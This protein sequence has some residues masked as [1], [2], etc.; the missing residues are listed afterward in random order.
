MSSPGFFYSAEDQARNQA[1]AQQQAYAQALLQQGQNPGNAQYGGLRSAGNSI[2]GAFLAKRAQDKELELS[3]GVQDRRAA[4]WARLLKGDQSPQVSTAAGT[5]PQMPQQMD[6]EGNA[7]APGQ[8]PGYQPPQQQAAPQG[9]QLPNP[10]D[11]LSRLINSGDPQFLE[12]FGPEIVK[13]RLELE[14]KHLNPLSPQEAQAR[15]LRGVWGVDAAGN[16]V[17]IQDSDVKSQD[18]EAQAV[19]MHQ[20]EQI[21][22][23]EALAQKKEIE[24]FSQAPQ[25]ANYNLAKQRLEMQQKGI[26]DP[27][28]RGFMADQ[29]L[30]GDKSAFANIGRGAQGAENLAALRQEVM[31]R[32]QARGL[33][34]ADLAAL[35]AEFS[36]LQAGERTLGTRTANIEMAAS[37]VQQLAPLALQA[38]NAVNRT[39]YPSLNALELAA[40]RGTGDENVVRLN[41]SVNALVNTYARAVSPSGQPTVN[42]KNH[43]REILDAAYSK[44]QFAAAIDQ[45]QKEIAAARRSPASV[46][47]EF[48]G[49]IS[50]SNPGLASVPDAPSQTAAQSHPANLPPGSLWSPSRQQYKTPDGRILDKNG[51]PL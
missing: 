29:V 44:G 3:K 50:G 1:L 26:L 39:Q 24:R 22:T 31:K 23:P 41:Q 10:N 43:A 7:M 9:G 5:A 36:G 46:R 38:S 40:K 30:A 35:N 37:E 51:K 42:D 21:L 47:G 14:N 33:G 19:R 6:P 20:Q 12:Q 13:N 8:G 18:A 17:K 48:R 4:A 28:T 27:D 34:G 32:A 15:G 2:L 49:A 16:P 11:F 45:M 25:W